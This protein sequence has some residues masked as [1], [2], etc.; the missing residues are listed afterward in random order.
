[1]LA[2]IA[3]RHEKS[4]RDST[5]WNKPIYIR[6]PQPRGTRPDLSLVQQEIL[7]QFSK[8]VLRRRNGLLVRNAGMLLR[9]THSSLFSLG[10]A[11][12]L[13]GVPPLL[14]L[15]QHCGARSACC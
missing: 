1:M 15:R 7:P 12:L 4:G 3:I 8:A 13:C 9:L 14:C 11:L 2:E 5:E 6:E 10:A